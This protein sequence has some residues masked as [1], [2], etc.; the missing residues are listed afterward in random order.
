[1]SLYSIYAKE[2][3]MGKI[4]SFLDSK[5]VKAD[6][7][8][9]TYL[10]WRE[11][12]SYA[13]GR[14]AQGMN[15]SMTSSKYVNYF[16]TNV[17]FKKLSNPMGT[18]STIRLFCGIFDAINDPIMGI[19]VDKTRTKDGQMRPYIKWAPVFVSI[20]MILFFVGSADA[21]PVFNIIYTT[22]LFVLL[23]VTYT[24][25]D[26]PM[27]ALAFSITPNGIERTK[28]FGVSS[29]TRSVVGALPQVFVA[30]AAWLPYF[31]D[32]TPQAYLTSAIISAIGIFFLTRLTFKNTTERAHHSSDTPSVKECFSLLFKNRPL[33]MLFL[34]NIFFVLCKVAEQVSF[35]FVADLMFNLKYN[36]VI[37][38]VKFPGFLLAGIIVPKIIE[39]LGQKADSKR[40][41]QMCCVSAII[42]HILFAVLTFKGLLQKES[43]TSVSLLTGITVCAFTCL[44]TI[45]LEFKNLI[46]KEM[47]AETVDYI[48]WKTGTRVEGIM[49]SI[50]SFTGKIE[51]TF[52]SSIGLAILGIVGYKSHTEGS[53]IQSASTNNML[54]FLTTLLPAVGY[55][56]ML[57]PMHFYNITGDGHRKMMKEIQERRKMHQAEQEEK[58]AVA[59]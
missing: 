20:V 31:R 49:L 14:G 58:E 15:T 21:P 24:A 13:L 12:L 23:D 22:I 52:S 43:G 42:L 19:L 3:K 41:Y 16:L 45:P 2:V 38:V 57:V 50:M 1:M 35:Y 18:A 5:I 51:N 11:T 30:G 54:F 56:L 9:E 55:L 44:T 29:I 28:L 40:F 59:E 39:K 26:I 27:G 7:G 53:L 8:E 36:A 25:F 33:L 34:G 17:L 32:H 4:K 47:E 46:Q 10:T 37:D 48:E 6:V